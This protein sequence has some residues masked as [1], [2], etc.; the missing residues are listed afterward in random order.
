MN[1]TF[2][3]TRADLPTPAFRIPTSALTLAGFRRWVKSTDFPEK[4]IKATFLGGEVFIDMAPEFFDTHNTIK[5]EVYGV[6]GPLV[7]AANTGRLVS[8]NMMFTNE[9]AE[10]ST[11]PDALFFTWE[12]WQSGRVAM[13]PSESGKPNFEVVGQP[14]MVLEVVSDSSVKKDLRD[15]RT[16]YHLAGIQEYWTIDA[17]GVDL[18]FEILRHT[19]AE[20]VAVPA[21]DGWVRS[22]VFGREFRLTRERDRIGLWQYTLHVRP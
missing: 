1:T 11:E 16:K 12:A 6:L 5:T 20:Y 13:A 15:L 8:D 9:S 21:A 3:I 4:G 22:A 17:R 10:I 2:T 18:T 7:K 19:N 14:D